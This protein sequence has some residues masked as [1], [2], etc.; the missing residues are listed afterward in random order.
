MIRHTGH[1]IAER[2]SG[3][4]SLFESDPLIARY[5]DQA[6]TKYSIRAKVAN[7]SEQGSANADLETVDLAS[8]TT[9]KSRSI[10]SELV[11]NSFYQALGFAEILEDAGVAGES[12]AITKAT[13]L[14]RLIHPGS[15]RKMHS[16]IKRNSVLAE[17]CGIDL[18]KF[19]ND[20]VYEIADTLHRSKGA[21]EPALFQ[22]SS[23]LFGCE[24]QPFLF[25]STCVQKLGRMSQQTRRSDDID[26]ATSSRQL[27]GA[28]P[29][30]GDARVL[31]REAPGLDR[32][33]RVEAGWT[34]CTVRSIKRI[35]KAS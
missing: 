5:A 30:Q 27:A 28:S 12:L 26:R 21:I 24:T 11:G 8:A 2:L 25:D 33:V 4:T 29:V 15:D 34:E 13:I 18:S 20:K 35:L 19:H 22:A 17:M 10:G 14:A 9:T 3:A 16:W 1:A 23:G 31:G 6:I 7:A 32:D